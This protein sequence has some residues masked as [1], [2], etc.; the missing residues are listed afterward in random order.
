MLR[1]SY[2]KHVVMNTAQ[3]AILD[4]VVIVDI[5][6]HVVTELTLH[7][8]HNP[9]AVADNVVFAQIAAGID[10]RDLA[11]VGEFVINR[12]EEMQVVAPNDAI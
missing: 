11:I 1:L 4:E 2:E 3:T 8:S 12:H 10:R 9:F 6:N 5:A 7:E